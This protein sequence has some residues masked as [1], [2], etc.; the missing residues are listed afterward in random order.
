[1][2]IEKICKIYN[3]PVEI[4]KSRKKKRDVVIL[5]QLYCYFSMKYVK[6]IPTLAA[7]GKEV[8]RNHGTVLHS[9][10]T[11]HNLM[12]TNKQHREEVGRVNGLFNRAL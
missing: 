10:R 5:R 1:M 7:I 3:V 12:Q 9:I 4:L 6:P 2:M 8:N 11:I